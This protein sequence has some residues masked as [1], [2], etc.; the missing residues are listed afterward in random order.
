MARSLRDEYGGIASLL[1]LPREQWEALEAD[2][3]R[4]GFTM[5]DVPKRVSHRALLALARH[6]S[7]DSAFARAQN[8][9]ME[10]WGALEHIS[11]NV[12]DVLASANWQRS[13]NANAARPQPYPRPGDSSVVAARSIGPAP[14]HDQK[15]PDGPLGQREGEFQYGR[16]PIPM[17]EFSKWWNETNGG[18]V[19]A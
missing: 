11:A 1:T 16:D 7:K 12:F 10:I 14:E 13:G 9:G 2:L 19:V 8:D 5:A 17:N 15:I 6:S 18:E 4:C 3:L